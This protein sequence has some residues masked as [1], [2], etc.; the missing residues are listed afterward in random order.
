M[1][2]WVDSQF[3][4]NVLPNT[5]EGDTL[6][7]AILLIKDYEDKNYRIPFPNPI[8][9]IKNKM[10]DK[11]LKHKNFVKPLVARRMFL[12]YF[13]NNYVRIHRSYIISK[14]KIE[15][16]SRNSVWL[17]GNEIPVGAS[18]ENKLM[19]IRELLRLS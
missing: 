11:G 19:E 13:T 12:L 7:M 9:A 1:H 8:E 18:Y 14:S 10:K 6:E 15:K 3:D 5:P 2:D 4:A 16:I 17:L